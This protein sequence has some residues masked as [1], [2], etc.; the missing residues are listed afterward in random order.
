MS[1]ARFVV[2]NTMNRMSSLLIVALMLLFNTPAWL[3]AETTPPM[4]PAQPIEVVNI[5]K[6][7]WSTADDHAVAR[8]IVSP[9][10]SRAR[11]VSIADIIVPPGVTIRRH[12]HKVIEEIYY[13]TAGEGIMWLNGATKKVGVGDAI[14]IRPGDV[15]SISNPT[16]KELRMIVTCTPA[17]TP[18]CLLFDQ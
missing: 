11:Q 3:A 12:H 1:I 13:I 8:Q 16:K 9:S 17:W 18:D 4:K 10:N 7:S 5:E 2:V 15:H 14:V 6:Q